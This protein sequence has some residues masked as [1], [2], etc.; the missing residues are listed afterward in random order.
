MKPSDVRTEQKFRGLLDLVAKLRSPDGC[1][2]DRSQEKGDIGRYLIEEAYEVLEALEGSSPENVQE[3][4]GDLL[5]QIVFHAELGDE[6]DLFNL[7]TI[8]D[9]VRDKL[10]GRHP[11]V[12]GDGRLETSEQVLAQWERIKAAEKGARAEPAVFKGRYILTMALSST[13][14][15]GIRIAGNEYSKY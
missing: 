7:A 9:A 5:F 6:E 10:T 13:Q 11:H 8:A 12:F 3:E 15:P 4:L 1:P 14:S 2:W